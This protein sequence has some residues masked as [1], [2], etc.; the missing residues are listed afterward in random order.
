MGTRVILL[1]SCTGL[2]MIFLLGFQAQAA[3]VGLQTYWAP[4][5]SFGVLFMSI[6]VWL[7]ENFA[8]S[9]GM[10]ETIA[11]E[12]TWPSLNAKALWRF[13]GQ[14]EDM[15][16]LQTGVNLAISYRL[17]DSWMPRFKRKDFIWT[18]ELEYQAME[19]GLLSIGVGAPVGWSVGPH[20]GS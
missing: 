18:M 7:F 16:N 4:E 5:A 20:L 6:R 8:V 11:G 14:G 17:E 12:K 13:I 9:W 15:L 3:E 10:G 19:R 2:L 1:L